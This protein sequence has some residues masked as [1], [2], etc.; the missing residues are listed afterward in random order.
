[1]GCRGGGRTNRRTAGPSGGS[2]GGDP[3]A[4]ADLRDLERDLVLGAD[5]AG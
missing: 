1:M 3:M 4:A 5:G 2:Y